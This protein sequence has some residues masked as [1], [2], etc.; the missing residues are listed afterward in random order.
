[1]QHKWR[2][3][4]LFGFGVAVVCLMIVLE[5]F[6][7]SLANIQYRKYQDNLKENL[8]FKPVN[9]TNCIY[10]LDGMIDRDVEGNFIIPRDDVVKLLPHNIAECLF[11]RYTTTLQTYCAKRSHHGQLEHSW[12][13]CIDGCYKPNSNTKVI[14]FSIRDDYPNAY[15][16]SAFFNST[17]Y[18][19]SPRDSMRKRNDVMFKLMFSNSILEIL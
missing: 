10:T 16:I 1:M 18:R 15:G 13:I 12:N 11:R 17:A 6:H 5:S 2:K 8:L 3:P 9:D 14:A 19:F 7:P 4:V